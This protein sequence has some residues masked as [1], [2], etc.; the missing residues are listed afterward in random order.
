MLNVLHIVLATP[1]FGSTLKV[2]A[3]K[4]KLVKSK[5]SHSR[6]EQ[7]SSP[8]MSHSHGKHIEQQSVHFVVKATHS[9][10]KDRRLFLSCHES[11]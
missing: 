11:F 5:Q 3:L 4:M 9:I 8:K 1:F 6:Q 10:R 2:Q 7:V